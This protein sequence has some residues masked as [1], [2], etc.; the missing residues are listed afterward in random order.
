MKSV[1]G[2]VTFVST[3]GGFVNRNLV[4]LIGEEALY[5]ASAYDGDF[6]GVFSTTDQGGSWAL[7][8]NRNALKGKNIL[9]FAVSPREAFRMLAGTYDGLLNSDDGG[10]TWQ[11]TQTG[12]VRG[13]IY[14]VAFSEIDT[15]VVYAA[16]DHGLFKSADGGKTWASNPASAL[17]T[18]VY[19]LALHPTDSK[20][21][22]ARTDRGVWISRNGGALWNVLDMGIESR[23]FDLAFSFAGSAVFAATSEGLLYSSDDGN[24]WKRM[25]NGLPDRRLDQVVLL[26]NKPHEIY[27]L[28]RDSHE[29]WMSPNNGTEWHKVETHGLEGTSLLSLSVIGGQPFMVTE[30]DG[31]FRLANQ[32]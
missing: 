11:I 25:E 26:R 31:I 2:G 32:K 3:N 29:M 16:T 4:R 23:V 1:D 28:R 22:L 5:V 12:G 18:T 8:A 24:T 6:G 10:K 19:K 15:N 13:K 17:N 7:N 9:S 30:S 20:L 14:D 27:V 21:M